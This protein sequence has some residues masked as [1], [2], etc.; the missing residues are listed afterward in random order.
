MRVNVF[1]S[2]HAM[3]Q[4]NSRVGPM[5]QARVVSLIRRRLANQL[6]VGLRARD[7]E[8][9]GLEICPGLTAVIKPVTGAWMVKTVIVTRSPDHLSLPGRQA[10]GY[11]VGRY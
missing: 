2:P 11:Q 6:A 8:A 5:K 7:K 3:D 10:H 9:F 4:W 1:M